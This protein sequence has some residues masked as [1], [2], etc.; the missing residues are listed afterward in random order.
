MLHCVPF[1]PA[2]A[3]VVNRYS[4]S[5]CRSKH[6]PHQSNAFLPPQVLSSNHDTHWEAGL[7]MFTSPSCCIVCHSS[8]QVLYSS[9][10]VVNRLVGRSIIHI[11]PMHLYSHK[12]LHT[13]ATHSLQGPNKTKRQT[14][15][16]KSNFLFWNR[17][18]NQMKI[19]QFEKPSLCFV[20]QLWLL[21][22][23]YARR[24]G[25]VAMVCVL[26]VYLDLRRISMCA[27]CRTQAV[28]IIRCSGWFSRSKHHTHRHQSCDKQVIQSKHQP[29]HIMTRV[30]HNSTCLS[31][32]QVR[33][34]I[35]DVNNGCSLQSL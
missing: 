8:Q 3:V 27:M 13:V 24:Y 25:C 29:A 2:S 10:A 11:T 12:Y 7:D 31:F 32:E 1:E 6:R 14:Y 23:L 33:W 17:S 30:C 21:L 9:I 26:D 15:I 34:S 28:D 19:Q 35:F 20:V 16:S 5:T 4:G 22:R 18:M